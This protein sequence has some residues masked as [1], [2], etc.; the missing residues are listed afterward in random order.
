M[1]TKK[2]QPIIDSI[3]K[4]IFN[5]SD[6]GFLFTSLRPIFKNESPILFDLG[7]FVAHNDEEVYSGV[8]FKHINK[9]VEN[10]IKFC[11]SVPGVDIDIPKSLYCKEEVISQ[12]VCVLRK[13][14]INFDENRL[15]VQK[16]LI[17]EYLLQLIDETEIKIDNKQVVKCYI[18]KQGSEVLFCF[19]AC[20]MGPIIRRN[21][22]ASNCFSLF[23]DS[24]N[25]K[26]IN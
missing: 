21:P 2:I 17:I 11:E 5:I 15:I 25:I 20:I 4:G 3:C 12:L 23:G 13:L 8:S 26:I 1:K 16:E 19:H 22:S 24:Q 18:K 10:Y 9:F 14:E 6:V 7:R